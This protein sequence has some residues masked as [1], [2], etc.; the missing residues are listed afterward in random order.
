MC[1][2]AIIQQTQDL[3]VIS[4]DSPGVRH[5]WTRYTECETSR[6][7]RPCY[8]L[9]SAE[10]RRWW[11]D[12]GGPTPEGYYDVK[13]SEPV[14][15]HDFSLVAIRESGVTTSVFADATRT[16]EAGERRTRIE[17]V[18]VKEPDGWK[19]SKVRQGGRDFVP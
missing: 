1:H 6:N 10:M 2:R 8:T 16:G 18:F 3:T 4:G 12:H 11:D 19:I 13:G 15:Y 7:F 5:A 14:G 17:Y 9:L